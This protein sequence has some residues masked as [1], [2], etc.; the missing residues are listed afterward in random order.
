[1]NK[2]VKH[3]KIFWWYEY[4]LF[5]KQRTQCRVQKKKIDMKEEITLPPEWI[6]HLQGKHETEQQASYLNYQTCR[7]NQ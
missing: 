4:L 6:G 7:I 1:M 5:L 2:Y 3:T